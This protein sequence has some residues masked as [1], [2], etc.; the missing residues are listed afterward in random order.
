MILFKSKPDDY[1][2]Y[3]N[4]SIELM[5]KLR[6]GERLLPDP[7]IQVKYAD[8]STKVFT[9]TDWAYFG[10]GI[11]KNIRNIKIKRL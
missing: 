6:K 4:D 8:K 11:I 1:S 3:I 5:E 10:E 9:R 2:Q 7:Y